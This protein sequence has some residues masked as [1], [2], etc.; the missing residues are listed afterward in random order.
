MAVLEKVKKHPQFSGRP[1]QEQ[2]ALTQELTD[3]KV[4]KEKFQ[5]LLD[6][7]EFE[8]NIREIDECGATHSLEELNQKD[9][10]KLETARACHLPVKLSLSKLQRIQAPF[11]RHFSTLLR[12]EYG[13]MHAGLIVGDIFIE[14][15]D[16]SLVVPTLAPFAGDVQTHIGSEGEWLDITRNA[17]GNMSLANRQHLDIP[18]KLEILYN[19]RAEKELL[20]DRLVDVIVKYNC[21]KQYSM[22][23]C[24][25]QDFVKDAL[26]SLGIKKL[27]K[28]EGNLKGYI[29]GLQGGK[30]ACISFKEHSELDDYVRVNVDALKIHEKEYLVLMYFQFH[31]AEMK[32]LSPEQQDVWKCP[33]QGCLCEDLECQIV[34]ESLHFYKFRKQC[35]EKVS[36]HPGQQVNK[37]GTPVCIMCDINNIL[38]SYWHACVYCVHSWYT[39]ISCS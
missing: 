39:S 36:L 35:E 10:Q 34:D 28:F 22:F 4:I 16:C 9:Q 18:K 17:V 23:R 37:G 21:Y 2:I 15:N 5:C 13:P 11:L 7:E 3:P 24:N 27:P 12:I 1:E 38:E 29:D 14:W 20:I 33:V 26:Q 6:I 32:E 8:A 30:A 25:C 19:S 31:M